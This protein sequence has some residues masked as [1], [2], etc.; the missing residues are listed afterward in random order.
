MVINT[1]QMKGGG[2]L[3]YWMR[4]IAGYVVPVLCSLVIDDDTPAP[5]S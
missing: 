3:G 5:C 2:D 4:W 1:L